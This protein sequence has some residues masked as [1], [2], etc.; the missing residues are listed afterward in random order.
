MKQPPPPFPIGE[1]F[2]PKP[3]LLGVRELDKPRESGRQHRRTLA[4]P[5]DR[6]PATPT[7]VTMRF[8]AIEAKTHLNFKG[9]ITWNDVTVDTSGFPI[10]TVDR[11]DVQWRAVDDDG[12]PIE[13]EHAGLTNATNPSGSTYRFTTAR[14]TDWV[15]GDSIKIRGC[16]PETNYN[17]TRD[18]IAKG[19]PNRFDVDGPSGSEPDARR[20]GEA[21]N[22][23]T[24]ARFRRKMRNPVQR[25]ALRAATHTTSPNK[26]HFTTRGANGFHAGQRITVSGCR[27]QTSYNGN[28]EID[29]ITGEDS[30]TVLGGSGALADAEVVG[31]V[32][33]RE[34][35]LHIIIPHV[36]RPKS[37]SWQ[38]RVRCRSGEGCWSAFSAW[39]E[40]IL[41]WEGAEPLPPAPT[42]GDFPIDFDHKGKGKHHKTRLLFTFDEVLDWDVPGGD[43]EEDVRAYDV[44][45]DSSENG[46]DWDGMPWRHHHKPAKDGDADTEVVAVFHSN[47][48]R[49]RWYRCRVRTVDRFSRK[50]D[51]SDWTPAAFPFDDETPPTPL[52]VEVFPASTDRVVVAW[53]DP[54]ITFP[55][56]GTVSGTSGTDTLTGIGTY[57]HQEIDP[58]TTVR[59]GDRVTGDDYIV[60]SVSTG[61]ALVLTTNL[62]TSPTD[63][64]FWEIA[65]DP[66]V[67]LYAVQIALFADVDLTVAPNVWSDVFAHDRSTG[68]RKAFK[69]PDSR[70]DDTFFARVRSIDAARNRSSWIPAWDRSQHS[71]VANS[72]PDVD[73]DGV[74]IIPGN[75]GVTASWT[76]PGVLPL[77]AVLPYADPNRWQNL[78]GTKL[79]FQRAHIEVGDREGGTGE[80]HVTNLVVQMRRWLTDGT[81]NEILFHAS[82]PDNRLKILAG[83]W[84]DSAPEGSF[85]VPSLSPNQA[86]SWTLVQVGSDANPGI[87]L[88]ISLF[89]STSPPV[90]H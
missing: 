49:H 32:T 11:W 40:S 51:W 61:T 57:F 46:V 50:G 9:R 19:A 53:D 31:K 71:D 76:Y 16:Y 20:V 74:V 33:D 87:D 89:M 90:Q 69:I 6:P 68:T 26:H 23:S 25:I 72:D 34:D 5:C 59:I 88:R 15:V 78:T 85:E 44:E 86:V 47:I 37:W 36:P 62:L 3:G 14:N 8:R 83:E 24:D 80:P 67:D 4:S 28:W 45:L 82:A 58:G 48:H 21:F 29:A 27:P 79:Y 38:A 35:N 55:T 7:G 13:V 1:A 66:D 42:Y 60:K 17:G 10:N 64:Q 54:M 65:E 73:G 43:R 18:I 63:A 77:N 30:F 70:V 22:M 81:T 39:T 84:S 56:R 75:P 12:D 41:P 2:A 52:N